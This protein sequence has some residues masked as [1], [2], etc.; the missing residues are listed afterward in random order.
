MGQACSRFPQ[1][2][3]MYDYFLFFSLLSFFPLLSFNTLFLCFILFLELLTYLFQMCWDVQWFTFRVLL[4]E[5]EL[6]RW[7]KTG[8]LPLFIITLLYSFYL[9]PTQL[10]RPP[11]PFPLTPPKLMIQSEWNRVLQHLLDWGTRKCA[12]LQ[13]SMLPR[14]PCV[15]HH[16]KTRQGV[17]W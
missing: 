11:H 3:H 1:C 17:A 8:T 10:S 7:R 14:V 9:L 16:V 5:G 2:G 13:T 4:F 6:L 12:M 15:L